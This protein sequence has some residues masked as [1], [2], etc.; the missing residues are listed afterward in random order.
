[1]SLNPQQMNMTKNSECSS[2]EI[3]TQLRHIGSVFLNHCEVSAQE[4]VYRIFSM[5][6]KQLSRKVVFINTAAKE[7]RVSL[8][9]SIGQIKNMEKDS[10]YI[11][12]ASLIDMQIYC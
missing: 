11:F 4:A 2:E 5:P 9:K 10:E 7:D 12:Q 8:L 6:L 1:M 3:R